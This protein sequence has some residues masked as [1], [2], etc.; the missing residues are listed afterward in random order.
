MLG[1]GLLGCGRI[2]RMLHLHALVDMDEVELRAVAE[3]DPDRLREAAAMEAVVICLPTG[4]HAEAASAAFEAGKHVF[5]EKPIATNE[6]EACRVVEAWTASGRVGMMG[7]NQRFHPVTRELK[8][9]IDAGRAGTVVGAHMIMGSEARELPDWKR[10]RASGGGALLELG[11]H[12]VDFSRYLFEREV[13]SVNATI[14]SVHTEHDTAALSMRLE[15]GPTVQAHVTLSGIQESRYEVVGDRGRIVADRSRETLTLDPVRPPYGRVAHLRAE[16][17]RFSTGLR[18]VVNLPS[19]WRSHH[20]ALSA[21]VDAVANER[22][23]TPDIE[24]GYR[25]LAVILAAEESDRTGRDV[26]VRRI[27]R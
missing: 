15:D 17:S 24:D 18:K 26:A 8:Q 10:S 4:L 16:L 13:V 1:I 19:P 23:V 5:L 11:S 22:H 25:S 27:G 12:V 9:A 3:S 7:F 2:A 14:A 20:A 6:S 21:F